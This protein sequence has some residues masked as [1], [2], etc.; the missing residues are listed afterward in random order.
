MWW[1]SGITRDVW[2]YRRPKLQLFD[3]FIR[4]SPVL[5]SDH[6]AVVDLLS[7][8]DGKCHV[9]RL[10]PVVCVFLTLAFEFAIQRDLP[11][12][13]SPASPLSPP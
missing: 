9:V 6:G 4:A 12:Q 1:L 8:V 13:A 5:A 2:F 10:H 11:A 3:A 7:P